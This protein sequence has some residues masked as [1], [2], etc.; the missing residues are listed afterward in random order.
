MT[1]YDLCSDNVSVFRHWRTAALVAVLAN[2]PDID[3]VIGLILQG[4]GSAFHRGPTHSIAFA[5]LMGF[6]AANGWK[7]MPR[8][9]KIGFPVCFILILSH[10]LADFFFSGGPVS[11]FWPLAVGYSDGYRDLGNVVHAALQV[12]KD[13]G[14]IMGC[15]TLVVCRRLVGTDVAF[16]RS[17]DKLPVIRSHKQE[18]R[19]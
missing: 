18:F 12:Y 19:R 2:L 7:I 14:I 8:L 15:G 17:L 11:F 5:L 16:H 9:P 4:N 13:F 1:A 6:L 3:M 10:L